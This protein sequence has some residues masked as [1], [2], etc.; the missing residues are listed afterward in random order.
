M[1][2][3]DL[4]IRRKLAL[5][6]LSASVLAVVLASVGFAIYERQNFR[7][8][9][10]TELTTLADTLGANTAA[11]LEFNDQ[12]TA[13]EMLEALAAERHVVGACLYDNQNYLFAEYRRRNVAAS[14]KLPAWQEDGHRFDRQ[15]LTLFRGVFL[16]GER[17]GT[18]AI[19]FDLSEF[20][21]KLQEYTK[22]AAWVLFISVLVT[23][24]AYSRVARIISEPLVQ[25]AGTAR[26]ISVDKDYSVRATRQAGGEIG[27]L[28]DSFNEM[29]AQIEIREQARQAAEN[30]LRE[31]EERYALAARGANDGLWD[32]KLTTNEIYFSS[33]WNHMLGYFDSDR[34]YDPEEWF[35]R[36]HPADRERVQHELVAHCQGRTS[37]FVSEYRM[38]HKNG[39]FIWTLSRGIAVRDSEGR[40]IRMA[41]SQTDITEGKIADPLTRLPNRLYFIDKLESCIEG[42]G[43][44]EDLF[45]VLF[46]DL[47]HFKLI[48]DS[49][50][51]AA[52]DELLMGVAR[53][54]RSCIRTAAREGSAAHSVAARFGGDEF[55]ILLRE[56]QDEEDVT[57]LADRILEKLHEPFHLE[58]RRMFVTASIGIAMNSSG[59][60][61][62]DLL[63]NADT[64]M[65][66]AKANGKARFEIFNQGM[67]ERAVA[68]LEI[69]TGLR[70]AIDARQLVLYYQP[71]LSLDSRQ[72]RGYEALVRWIHPER[73]LLS[74]GEFIP[75]AEESDLILLVGR[76]VL[77]EACRQMAEWHR[78][79]A[80]NSPLTISINVSPKQLSDGQLVEDVRRTLAETGLDPRS[81]NLELTESSIMGNSQ[82]TL[83]TLRELKR[84]QI[85]LEIDDFGTGYSSL[86]YLQRL[87]FDAIK[88]DRSFVK[89]VA[90]GNESSEI[91]RTILGLARSLKMET[92]AEGVETLEQLRKLSEFGCNYV[93]GYY[94]SRPA[95]AEETAKRIQE[96][97]KTDPVLQA[98]HQIKITSGTK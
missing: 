19:V 43:L 50:G 52:G 1:N 69:E 53:R 77:Q 41:G 56:V 16:N 55:A 70:K 61:P 64:A 25:L 97:C 32:W 5:L 28:I 12:K 54:L 57:I 29:L 93:Q 66:H 75:V 76:W 96:C 9:A 21:A 8:N 81:L 91:V 58:G 34:W 42:A 80:C 18:I 63:R 37:E 49:L 47:D 27:L 85:G 31:S 17:A 20:S 84:M 3:N 62:E 26:R 60:T 78:C 82:Q 23:Y 51:H 65:Y 88:I 86:S 7:S 45:A 73:G 71:V 79:L 68:R 90:A 67:R 4:P 22:I 87:P 35:S 14:W 33:R 15:S 46:L 95:S 36:I 2:F 13:R 44:R 89:E 48:N 6:I 11:S 30:S 24:L 10:V 40:A 83:E 59:S 72:I 92:V 39:N 74:P 94:F 38:R 98:I